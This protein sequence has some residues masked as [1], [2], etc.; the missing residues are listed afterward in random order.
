MIF[1]F[2]G[3]GNSLFAAK[4]LG[5]DLISIPQVV[6]R[7]DISYEAD[8]IGIVCPI[9]GHEMPQMVKTFLT[10]ATLKTD[11]LFVVLTY[12]KM[13]ANAVELAMKVL[14]QSGKKADYMATVCMVDNFVPAFDMEKEMAEDKQVDKQLARIKKDIGEKKRQMEEVTKADREVHEG[15]RKM[16]SGRPETIWADYDFTSRCIG[17]GICTRVCPAGCIH[18]ENRQA[19][20]TGENCQACM[21]CV[22]ACPEA[23]IKVNRVL[24]FEEPNPEARYRNENVSLTEL[25]QANWRREKGT[26]AGK[27]PRVNADITATES[28]VSS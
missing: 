6:D 10:K 19:V 24:E 15:Y 12:G 20:R 27:V 5:E 13:H 2:T 8:K 17:C 16:V 23:A 18:L 11:Y 1:Y 28:K 9:Y 7:E 4:C 26:G 14:A 3:T 25:V 21:A 22:H